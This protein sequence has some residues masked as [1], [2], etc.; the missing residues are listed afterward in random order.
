MLNELT[1]HHLS[2][3]DLVRLSEKAGLSLTEDQKDVLDT[4]S[5]FNIQARYDDYKMAFHRKCSQAFTEKWIQKIKEF[6]KWIKDK[7]QQ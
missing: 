2:S 7:L 4:I 6:R 3:I 1:T 5:T